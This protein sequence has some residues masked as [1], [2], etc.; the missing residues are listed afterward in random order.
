MPLTMYDWIP[1]ASVRMVTII[2]VSLKRVKRNT[3][4]LVFAIIDFHLPL[5]HYGDPSNK[6]LAAIRGS[7][8]HQID[9]RLD[10]LAI[11]IPY[12]PGRCS[13]RGIRLPN[14]PATRIGYLDYRV[15]C[16]AANTHQAV[17][18]ERHRVGKNL[19]SVESGLSRGSGRPVGNKAGGRSHK[20]VTRLIIYCD[21]EH[22]VGWHG[23]VFPVEMEDELIPLRPEEP[24]ALL[25]PYPFS[26][27]SV[28]CDC[29]HFLARE[30]KASF[31]N[32]TDR[33]DPGVENTSGI[34]KIG[35]PVIR[36]DPHPAMSVRSKTIHV[37]VRKPSIRFIEVHA[38]S[39][40]VEYQ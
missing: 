15:C 30:Q 31:E 37:S 19:N 38:V 8:E 29:R 2:E 14:E 10:T 3:I 22:A 21:V 40:T 28:H 36:P 13:A 17:E 5:F 7:A 35:Y 32:G 11:V 16:Q 6:V 26:V 23:T 25:G 24:N 39:G 34:N 27:A 9:A 20:H 12:V 4:P 18:L 1:K 33:I